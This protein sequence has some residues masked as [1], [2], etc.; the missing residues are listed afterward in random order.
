MKKRYFILAG[1]MMTAISG[2]HASY[3]LDSEAQR[4]G[5]TIG[6]DMGSTLEEFA[7]GEDV[8][9]F[10]AL[11]VGLK[12]AHD[13]NELSMTTEEMDTAMQAFA[14]KRM[15][16]LQAE[17]AELAE[18]AQEASQTFLVDNA[19]KE[20]VVTTDSGLQYSVSKAGDGAKPT[21]DSEVTVHYEGRLIDGS[22]F[23]SSLE[24]GEPVTF[25]VEEVIDGWVEGL[26]L[27]QE[28]ASYTFYIPAE[29]G[30]GD[31]GAGPSIPPNSTL[32]FDVELIK[33]EGAEA[34]KPTKVAEITAT[35]EKGEAE[36]A[37]TTA[38]KEK[39]E[40]EKEVATTTVTEESGETKTADSSD[41]TK[42]ESN[43]TTPE[44]SSTE[45]NAKEATEPLFDKVAEVTGDALQQA[46]DKAEA[47]VSD[48][49][50]S[51]L[52]PMSD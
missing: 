31:V 2:A 40:A 20:G 16:E 12:D 43:A 42:A 36:G 33:V 29:L 45:L 1:A 25:K 52:N 15:A 44:T 24:R 17:Q 49:I 13:G 26:Q 6:V 46:G 21:K 39:S 7:G 18:K 22:V 10:N 5:Y 9:D 35:E 51:A 34:S 23:D 30:Y 32:V 47:V 28:G 19:K 37:A 3:Q 48:A 41:E 8:L 4:I 11:I 14:K 27:M 50:D 38:T